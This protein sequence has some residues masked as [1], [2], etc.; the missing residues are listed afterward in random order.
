MRFQDQ[1]D[2]AV[3][4]GIEAFGHIDIVLANAGVFTT[5]EGAW[6]LSEGGT[7]PTCANEDDAY[8]LMRYVEK[9]GVA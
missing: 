5:A 2:A 4:A 9:L 6:A 3:Q 8:T 7:K 1:L